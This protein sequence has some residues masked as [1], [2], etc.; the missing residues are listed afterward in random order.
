MCLIFIFYLIF[1]VMA[2][3]ESVVM[4]SAKNRL[5]EVVLTTVKGRTI[6]RKYQANVHDAKTQKQINQRNRMA[7]CIQLYKVLSSAVSVGFTNRGKLFSVY[8][9]FVSN[10][11][12]IM[13][14]TRYDT[15][16]GIIEDATGNIVISTGSLGT[17]A[18]SYQGTVVQINFTD[19]KEKFEVGDNV[20]LFGLNLSGNI[21]LVSDIVLTQSNLTSGVLNV[22]FTVSPVSQQYK[23]GAIMYKQNRQGST[24]A[25]LTDWIDLDAKGM[26]AE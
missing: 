7:N 3:I 25:I 18:V 4:G 9:A 24:N 22:N 19:I 10:N 13:A 23:F 2:V 20:R 12:G 8:N 11:I 6:A 17:P 14:A 15:V 21:A 26:N 5:G 16:D 1:N